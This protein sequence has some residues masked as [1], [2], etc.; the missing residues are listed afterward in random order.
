[1][2][3]SSRPLAKVKLRGA[4][5]FEG[6]VGTDNGK[7]TLYTDAGAWLMAGYRLDGDRLTLTIDGAAI[8]YRR[9]TN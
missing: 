5:E 2:R 1:M 8:D 6:K 7:L 9:K 3:W 4:V